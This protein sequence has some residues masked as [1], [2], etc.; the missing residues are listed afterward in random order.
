MYHVSMDK[1]VS[2]ETGASHWA[3]AGLRTLRLGAGMWRRIGGEGWRAVYEGG[4]K[5]LFQ[6]VT[7]GSRTIGAGNGKWAISEKKFSNKDQNARP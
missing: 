5:H 6:V 2:S 7:L 1:I 3:T 4:A